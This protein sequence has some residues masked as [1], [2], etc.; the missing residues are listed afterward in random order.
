MDNERLLVLLYNAIVGLEEEGYT[1]DDVLEYCA[2]TSD[3]YDIVMRTD[4]EE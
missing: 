2:M 1:K 4:L 3:E